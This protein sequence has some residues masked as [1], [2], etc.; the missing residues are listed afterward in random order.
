MKRPLNRLI[1][2][3]VLASIHT[4]SNIKVSFPKNYQK[5]IYIVNW[6]CLSFKLSRLKTKKKYL[7]KPRLQ[8]ELR[9]NF[10]SAT[11]KKEKKKRRLS[12]ADIKPRSIRY[13]VAQ[14]ASS[15]KRKEKKPHEAE[16][17][18]RSRVI[19]SPFNRDQ[20]V[21]ANKWFSSPAAPVIAIVHGRKTNKEYAKQIS[22]CA[23][24]VRERE[25]AIHT[26]SE[27]LRAAAPFFRG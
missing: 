18:K 15:F 7:S 22:T 26:P 9:V 19:F 17:T 10:A 8:C 23:R 20:A 1:I 16:R 24:T 25:R 6:N 21:R 13:D 27:K 11:G 14:T 2:M 5:F 3:W 4:W 12:V